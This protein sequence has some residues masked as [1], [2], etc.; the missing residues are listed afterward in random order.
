MSRKR[1]ASFSGVST[2]TPPHTIDP[3]RRRSASVEKKSSAA[4]GAHQF[5]EETSTGVQ[6]NRKFRTQ[7]HFTTY[8]IRNIERCGRPEEALRHLILTT[9]RRAMDNA[10]DHFG[11]VVTHYGL[12]LYHDSLI[13]GPIWVPICPVEQNTVD[14]VMRRIEDFQA[15]YSFRGSLYEGNLSIKINTISLPH[16]GGGRSGGH[17]GGGGGPGGDRK[18]VV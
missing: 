16:G 15:S 6:W 4:D 1:S 13:K 3:K 18:S 8:E 17:G 10:R 14:A 11:A 5:F 12:T 2:I 7:S 9:I